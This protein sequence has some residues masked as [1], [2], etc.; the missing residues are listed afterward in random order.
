MIKGDIT[1]SSTDKYIIKF[2]ANNNFINFVYLYND[3]SL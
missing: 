1:K 3:Y 2:E